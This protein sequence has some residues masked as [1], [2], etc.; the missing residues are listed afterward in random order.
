MNGSIRWR[1]ALAGAFLVSTLPSIQIS[2]E[3]GAEPAAVEE[4][5]VVTAHR[6]ETPADQVGSTVT[7]LHAEDLETLAASDVGEALRLVPGVEISRTGGLGQVTSAF[8]RGGSSSQTLVL[9]DGVRLNSATSG[10]YDFADLTLDDVERIEI[11][12]GPQSTLYGSEAVAGVI[13]IFTRPGRP[14]FH[15]SAAAEA[16]EGSYQRLR[17][18]ID[19][20]D[21][22]LDW[23]LSAA[24]DAI[25]A[26]SA[27]DERRGNREADAHDNTTFTGRLGWRLGA[28]EKA[29]RLDVDVRRLDG[30]TELDGF[31][32][33][34]GPVDDLD[35]T[36]ERRAT[37]GRAA[38]NASFGSRW[39]Q[40]FEVGVADDDLA[41]KDPTDPFNVFAIDSRNL[42][43]GTQG[44]L[45][46]D[47]HRLS[48][49]V[50][51]EE[52]RG[53]SA[54]AFDEEVEVDA[55]YLQ[56]LWSL[57]ERVHLTVGAR[58][59]D[60]SAF[61][62]ETTWR[63]ALAWQA[64]A[65]GRLHA[66]AGTGFK[67]PTLNDLYYPFFG[68]PNLQPERSEAF[69]I[70]FSQAWQGGRWLLDVTFFDSDFEDLIAY[71]F[72]TSLPQNIA[73][74]S[75]RGVEASL[76]WRAEDG[77]WTADL[78]HTW[79]ETEDAS[80]GQQ[81]ARRPE[82]RSVLR[83]AWRPDADWTLGA[84][85]MAIAD[86]IDSDG[87]A[88][89]DYQRIDL[90]AT[91]QAHPRLTPSLRVLNLLDD[92]SSEVGGYGAQGRVAIAGLRTAW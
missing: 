56:D 66:S 64:G 27:A 20:G 81:L 24:D 82:S 88:L 46:L 22:R 17:A 89:E 16:G 21:E 90:A 74:A 48:F 59:D 86:R 61:G 30:M 65:E 47:V 4:E 40:S 36:I 68:N 45:D 28:T 85:A 39:R 12:R 71:D 11:V 33:P 73:S 55:A 52:R 43:F 91:W 57:G 34:Q 1:I 41:G 23:R 19:G 79:N 67:A 37:Y 51:R 9:L 75:S 72:V 92:D 54:G 35:A 58:R 25:D 69:D 2:A 60:H 5:I 62:G 53:G 80:T 49:G 31:A 78:A 15:G 6:A 26:T 42:T 32:F 38:L 70:G 10:A 87:A 50:A 44:D 13:Q 14:G 84:V 76:R 3:T 77:R 8:V 83:V 29:P 63:A 18:G 7:V